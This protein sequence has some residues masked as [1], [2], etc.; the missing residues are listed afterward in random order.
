MRH[1]HDRIAEI[2]LRIDLYMLEVIRIK[3]ENESIENQQIQIF[4]DL[5]KSS[6]QLDQSEKFRLK[7]KVALFLNE[8]FK[9]HSSTIFN[10]NYRQHLVTRELFDDFSDPEKFAEIQKYFSQLERRFFELDTQHK[11]IKSVL[12]NKSNNVF[13]SQEKSDDLQRKMDSVLKDAEAGL[14]KQIESGIIVFEPY[15]ISPHSLRSFLKECQFDL[16]EIDDSFSF[17]FVSPKQNPCKLELMNIAIGNIAGEVLHLNLDKPKG[18]NGILSE[19]WF[20]GNIEYLFKKN[21]KH[22]HIEVLSGLRRRLFPTGNEK[23]SNKIFHKI[24]YKPS[25]DPAISP[26]SH[27]LAHRICLLAG[28]DASILN[29]DN[30]EMTL[31]TVI[32]DYYNIEMFNEPYLVAIKSFL[33]AEDLIQKMEFQVRQLLRLKDAATDAVENAKKQ[34]EIFQEKEL[35]YLKI[36]QM[37]EANN[38]ALACIDRINKLQQEFDDYYHQVSL[39][40]SEMPHLSFSPKAYFVLTD[41]PFSEKICLQLEEK[42]ALF[43]EL[44]LKI[45]KL[46]HQIDEHNAAVR[47]LAKISEEHRELEK[48]HYRLTHLSNGSEG[49]PREELLQAIEALESAM[50]ETGK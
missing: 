12:S 24:G 6:V 9:T 44:T 11:K 49:I 17:S 19:K 33:D 43:Q 46:N 21:S 1:F 41:L 10:E 4:C 26:Y 23:G 34:L 39:S 18:K 50:S 16:S 40:S 14:E 30:L 31:K 36:R 45:E 2:E 32:R 35:R 15:D 27:Q 48:H 42:Q 47:T 5:L 25:Y 8:L 3:F 28:A 7:E 29:K 37:V 38:K 13:F 20:V 22:W